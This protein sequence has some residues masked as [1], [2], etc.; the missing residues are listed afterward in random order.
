MGNKQVLVYGVLETTND[1]RSLF[2]G[3]INFKKPFEFHS[4]SEI[5]YC[6]MTR[7]RH[8]SLGVFIQNQYT[9]TIS[10]NKNMG[11]SLFKKHSKSQNFDEI[12]YCGMTRLRSTI[13]NYCSLCRYVK[14]T[15]PKNIVGQSIFKSQ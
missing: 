11:Q 1:L 2:A 10:R 7:L 14:T 5:F 13:L 6:D 9:R 4:F 8:M 15:K 12:F 3:H